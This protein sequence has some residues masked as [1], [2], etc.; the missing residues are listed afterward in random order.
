MHSFTDTLPIAIQS[1]VIHSYTTWIDYMYYRK[2]IARIIS[3]ANR[4]AHTEPLFKV[5]EILPI[6]DINIYIITQF[7]FRFNNGLLP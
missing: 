6:K 3:H 4:K 7:M 2:K 1:R 5:L